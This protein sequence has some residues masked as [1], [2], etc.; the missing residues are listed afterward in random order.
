[1]TA[2][3]ADAKPASPLSHRQVLA[4][5]GGLLMGMFLASLDQT[6]VSTAIRTIADDLHGYDLQA[7]V[8]TAYLITSTIATPLYGKLSDI[9]G[10]RPFYLLAIVVFV[11]GSLLCATATSMYELA[12]YRAVQGIGAGGLMS[13]ALAIMGDIV[14]PR[15]RARYQGYF[16]A[17]FGTSAVLGPVLGGLFAEQADIFGVSGWRWVFLVNVPVGVLAL[18]VVWR[19][20]HINQ[21]L[22]KNIKVDWWGA[23]TLTLGLVP[24]LIVA[25]QGRTWGWSSAM[26]LTCYIVGAVGVLAFVAIEKWMGESAIIPLRIFADRQFAQGIVISVLVGAVM[27]GGISMLPQYFQVVRDASPMGSG[28]LMLPMV[29]GLMLGS[30]VAG[31][32]ISRTGRYRLHPIVG[33]GVVAVATFVMHWV[34]ADTKLWQV[35]LLAAFLGFG[36]G[37][38]LPSVTM[39]LQN[40]L[41]AKDMGVSTASATFFRQ[42]GGTLG[43]AIFF[44]VLFSLVGPNISGEFDAAKATPEFQQA[45]VAHAGD[46]AVSG[47]LSGGHEGVLS[48]T[49]IIAT[50]PAEIAHPIK[51]GFAESMDVVFLSVSVI[52]LIAFLLTLVW[53]EV[54]LRSASGLD[55]QR[56]AA[57]AGGP[58]V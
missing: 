29:L 49:S 23:T 2:A 48:D 9:F 43:V 34:S 17:V 31:Q 39:A 16:M 20:L 12:A 8:T 54:P 37:N 26:S 11:A 38:I 25:E 6:I 42:I 57:E 22:N 58:V 10:R 40:M 3:S 52:A 44:S 33:T 51:Q 13:L 19:L 56:A 21:T 27:F 32:L 50:L 55:E 30:M 28:L 47:L 35:E 45:V 15:E 1:M 18:A 4:I 7:W 36:L 46:P 5:L 14:A 53:R 41:P 24:L